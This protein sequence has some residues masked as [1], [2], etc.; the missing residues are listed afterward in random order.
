MGQTP[1]SETHKTD[2]DVFTAARHALDQ[3]PNVPGTVRVHVDHGVATLT[4]SVRLPS[5]RA[6]AEETVRHVDGVR[7]IV[8]SITVS[9][10]VS[11]EGFEPPG[12]L[13]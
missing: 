10:R 12:D 6:E 4:G 8:N 5:E 1:P 9:Q 7:R 13:G 3:R 2:A 11:A